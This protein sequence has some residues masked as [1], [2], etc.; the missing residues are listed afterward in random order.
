MLHHRLPPI[1][2][3]R[4]CAAAVFAGA[5]AP[6]ST[7][8]AASRPRIVPEPRGPRLN[9]SRSGGAGGMPWR[10]ADDGGA[11]PASSEG[12]KATGRN[13]NGPERPMG[14]PARE[15]ERRE[16]R[17]GAW[18]PTAGP[19]T[20]GSRLPRDDRGRPRPLPASA[21]RTRRR[22]TWNARAASTREIRSRR[23]PPPSRPAWG[24]APEPHAPEP[25][26]GRWKADRATAKAPPRVPPGARTSPRA[27]V[28]NRRLRLPRRR[29]PPQAAAPQGA[30]IRTASSSLRVERSGEAVRPPPGMVP[31]PQAPRAVRTRALQDAPSVPPA[32]RSDGRVRPPAP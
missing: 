4:R 5:R 19:R 23:L 25:R 24:V 31:V 17:S 30:P 12:G 3:R 32:T 29:T 8:S 15:G 14:V 2:P 18:S 21:R 13:A 1:R 28:R 16:G 6:P 22:S 9:P 10:E 26:A 27:P 7:A 20:C 11:G